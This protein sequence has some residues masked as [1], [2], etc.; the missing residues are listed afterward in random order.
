LRAC[1][2]CLALPGVIARLDRGQ[3]RIHSRG[4]LDRPVKPGNDSAENVD[5]IVKRYNL[6]LSQRHLLNRMVFLLGENEVGALARG[7]DVF[8]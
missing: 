8:V 2:D 5:A 6:Q 3:A 4:V 7:Q 1:F